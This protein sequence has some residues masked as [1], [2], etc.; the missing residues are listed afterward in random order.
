MGDMVM[1]VDVVV[2]G[3]GP[4]G[5]SAAFRAAELGLDVAL[6]DPR[7]QPGGAYL[8]DGCIPAKTYLHLAHLLVGTQTAQSMGIDFAPPHI[9]LTQMTSWK[10]QVVEKI[11]DNLLS[12]SSQRG[13]QLIQGTVYFE[14]STT[15]RLKDSEI[16]RLKFTHAIIATGAHSLP[17]PGAPPFSH[18]RVMDTTEA[19]KLTEIPKTMLITGGGSEGIELGTIYAALGCAVYITEP[20]AQLLPGIDEDLVR[21]LAA[22][23]DKVFK[24]IWLNTQITKIT[25]TE[26][27]VQVEIETPHGTEYHNY[28]KILIAVGR[29]PASGELG[30]ENTSVELDEDG[31]IKTNS[32][33]HTVDPHIFAVGDVTNSRML[34]HTAIRDGNV[35]AEVISGLPSA[36]DVRAIPQIV[37]TNPQIAWC[38]LTEAEALQQQRAISVETFPWKDSAR[39]LTFGSTEGL[40]KIVVS[41]GSGR[42]LGA[43]ITGRGAEDLIAEWVLAIEMGAVAEDIA[44]CLHGHPTLSEIGGDASKK[45]QEQ[46]LDLSSKKS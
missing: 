18:G 22:G 27:D 43:G 24:Q 39:A 23:L 42:I 34:A 31:F 15:L 1:T 6:V 3:S 38:G 13:V 2:I 4:G 33:Q 5:Y 10:T 36:F 9:D 41:Q 19:L 17:F 46:Q 12:L 30:L 14:N 26:K 32:Q 21:P 28:D 20:G 25:E 16:A 44:L 35:A 45:L 40:T 37:Y 8:Y 11:A 29:T 7:P